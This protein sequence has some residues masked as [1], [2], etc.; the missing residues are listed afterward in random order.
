[1]YSKVSQLEPKAEFPELYS[2]FS[3]VICL[4]HGICLL[5]MV[6]KVALG[7]KGRDA[8]ATAP[9][10]KRRPQH[11]LAVFHG[12][13][14]EISEKVKSLPCIKACHPSV[15]ISVEKREDT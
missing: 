6:P 8:K 13:L 1:M 12:A 9:T 15:F 3:L 11:V 7:G 4:G 5:D 10:K 14:C 2:S